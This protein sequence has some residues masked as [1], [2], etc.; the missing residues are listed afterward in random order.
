MWSRLLGK[1]VYPFEVHCNFAPGLSQP[2]GFDENCSRCMMTVGDYEGAILYPYTACVSPIIRFPIVN[3]R[4]AW[5]AA[6]KR[7]AAG[8]ETKLGIKPSLGLVL[9]N[10]LS[11]GDGRDFGMKQRTVWENT[12]WHLWMEFRGTFRA[13]VDRKDWVKGRGSGKGI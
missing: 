7:P 13:C 12:I 1:L 2:D 5:T 9:Y 8:F 4:L 10:P 11:L 6:K 3:Q